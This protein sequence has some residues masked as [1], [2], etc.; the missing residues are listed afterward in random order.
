MG[1]EQAFATLFSRY[2]GKLYHYTLTYTQSKEIA[3]DLVHEVFLKIW[4]RREELTGIDNFNAYLYRMSRNLAISG[5]R[6]RAREYLMLAELR[7]DSFEVIPDIDPVFVKEVRAS[8]LRA[9]D[10]LSPQ[11]RKIFILSREQGLRQEQIAEEL[12][13]SINTVKTHMSRALQ[14]LR[15]EI[16][17]DYGPLAVAIYVIY[18]LS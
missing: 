9:I 8:I 2:R 11:Q 10:K 14:L 18:G 12:G 5:L 3:E 13:I 17:H 4:T 6:R 7:Q 15:E 16:G 1:D